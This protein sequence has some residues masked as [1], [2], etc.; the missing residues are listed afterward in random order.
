MVMAELPRPGER[1]PCG[2]WTSWRSG[3]GVVGAGF[4]IEESAFGCPHR[5]S[6]GDAVE[7]PDQSEEAAS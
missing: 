7:V 6:Q 1:L 4:V 2:C 3:R 5:H